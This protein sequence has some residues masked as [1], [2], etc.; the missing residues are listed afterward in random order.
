MIAAALPEGFRTPFDQTA[1]L[2]E[3]KGTSACYS[4]C[5]SDC[6]EH[7]GNSLETEPGYVPGHDTTSSSSSRKDVECEV[8]FADVLQ[9]AGAASVEVTGGPKLLRHV[10]PGRCDA[11]GPDGAFIL[12]ASHGQSVADMVNTI[13]FFKQ[14]HCAGTSHLVALTGAHTLG[15]AHSRHVTDWCVQQSLPNTENS[16]NLD[17]TPDVF[18]NTFW[19]HVTRAECPRFRKH[20]D[21]Y[22]RC[23][24]PYLAD[25]YAQTTWP[26]LQPTKQDCDEPFAWNNTNDTLWY[27][28][29][30]DTCDPRDEPRRCA[31]VTSADSGTCSSSVCGGECVPPERSTR[32]E[33]DV[34]DSALTNREFCTGAATCG[35]FHS[36]HML[37]A[38][39]ETYR[40]VELYAT[41]QA[42]FFANYALAHVRMAHVGCE[43]CGVG[44]DLTSDPCA[45][46]GDDHHDHH[47]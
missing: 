44:T 35:T 4:R 33:C 24:A 17:A 1:A 25:S 40:E 20:A 29:W 47:H 5:R 27:D 38:T 30:G 31:N 34:C 21:H 32:C 22:D 6:A 12:P 37:W 7:H 36:D 39:R 2:A 3:G 28:R 23:T 8:S 13:P 16:R 43:A 41:D 42:K 9:Y 46:G 10:K 18:D 26:R 15:H 14:C 19:K 45:G 11:N